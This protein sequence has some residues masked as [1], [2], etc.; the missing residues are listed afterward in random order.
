MIVISIDLASKSYADIG[1]VVLRRAGDRITVEP[2]QLTPEKGFTGRPEAI[3][4][5][6]FLTKCA[7][8]IG[9]STILID[10]PQAWKSSATE[11]KHSRRCERELAT[12]GKTGLPGTT[13][14]GTY[15]NFTRFS[16]DLFDQLQARGWPRLATESPGGLAD[17]VTIESFPTAAWRGL[18]LTPLPGKN[19]TK[20][21]TLAEKQEEL[22]TLFSLEIDDALNHDE[23]QALAGGLAGLALA[24]GRSDG[25][26]LA[27]SAPMFEGSYWREGFI[28]APA[29]EVAPSNARPA[30]RIN[31]QFNEIL[32]RTLRVDDLDTLGVS[33]QALAE[34]AI[35]AGR[36]E[37]AIALVDYFH[38]EMRIM[39]TIMRTWL[40][41]ITRYLIA[42]GGP[43]DN[44]GE[45]SAAL[46]DI[47]RT[48]PLGDALRERCKA[49][50]QES[51]LG[52]VSDRAR[53]VAEAINLLDQMRLEFKY[54]HDVLVAWVQD[55]LTSIAARWGEE[56]VLESILETHQSIWGDRYEN[57]A[58]MTPHE[59]LA[60]T[61][62]GMRGGHFSGE[63]RRGD[64]TVRDDGDRLVMIMELCGSG[65]VL[66]RGD[67]ET[68]RGPHPVGE[69][70]A[71][72]ALSMTAGEGD[73]SASLS[74]TAGEG[75]ASPSLSMTAGEG[76]ASATLS[77]T[78]VNRT[79]HDWTWQKTGVHWYCSHCAIAMEWLPGRQ[80]GR[81][82]R[83]LD[84]VMDPDAPCTWYIYKDEAQTRAYHYPRTG[85][86]T[87][88]D[89]PDR[90]EHWQEEYAGG[91]ASERF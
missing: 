44:A 51:V 53:L 52:P 85:T 43:S 25:Y 84:H 42:R 63:R 62:E 33:T 14:P 90:G 78:G 77:M 11:L 55:L 67:P 35:R 12:P 50:T 76:D 57:W 86:P 69:G 18:K 7:A 15:L 37:E 66:R 2:I 6:D 49:T 1:V 68:G 32:G 26:L 31:L 46:L 10:G 65:G 71:S 88:A 48:Y 74:M 13:K 40:T 45:L 91:L 64:V 34:E 20:P 54:P 28:I 22:E 36:V 27:G 5:A 61:V 19:N 56:A 24:D 3:T 75:D 16:I 47:W 17:R 79:P 89:A 83:P 38:Q 87:P 23:L 9:A 82:L 41:D 39:H 58:R 30:R 21:E 81:L 4:L 72:A 80:R 73:A 70:D 60:L 29:R 59:R 8:E